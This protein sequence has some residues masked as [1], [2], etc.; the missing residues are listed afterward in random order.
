MGWKGVILLA[1]EGRVQVPGPN[2]RLQD[3]IT[4]RLNDHKDHSI[5]EEE[6]KKK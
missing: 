3:P 5:V 6:E 2:Q 4:F 1:I